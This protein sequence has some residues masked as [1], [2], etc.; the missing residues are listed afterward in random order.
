[1][2]TKDCITKSKEWLLELNH[3]QLVIALCGEVN[4]DLDKTVRL[5]ESLLNHLEDCNVMKDEY[6]EEISSLEDEFYEKGY[7]QAIEDVVFELNNQD[8]GSDV[9]TLIEDM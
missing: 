9:I 2:D 8:V 4:H 5:F 3:K 1:M 6:K 7:N